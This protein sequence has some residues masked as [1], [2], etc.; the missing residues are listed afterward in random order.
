MTAPWIWRSRRTNTS[1]QCL[2]SK[3]TEKVSN[4]EFT[5]R[6]HNSF[7]PP[8]VFPVGWKNGQG[9]RGSRGRIADCQTADVLANK[10]E[11]W[12]VQAEAN[13]HARRITSQKTRFNLV[14]VALNV[15]IIDGVLDLLESPPDDDSFD[16]LKARLVQSFKMA[17]VDKIK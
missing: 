10:P 13:F 11:A 15:D 6:S 1:E 16:K 3:D 4:P 5:F 2:G 8:V 12:F 9:R 17:K 7:A 14:V